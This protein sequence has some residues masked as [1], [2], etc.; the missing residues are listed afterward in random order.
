MKGRRTHSPAFT[1][2][3]ASETVKGNETVA[4]LAARSEVYPGQIFTWKQTLA[5]GTDSTLRDGQEQKSRND[6]LARR[7]EITL[8]ELELAREELL[9][10]CHTPKNSMELIV[11]NDILQ[12][13]EFSI[14]V[15]GSDERYFPL[16]FQWIVLS[17]LNPWTGSRYRKFLKVQ[18]R[19]RDFDEDTLLN[20][21]ENEL[22][23]EG[24]E[25]EGDAPTRSEDDSTQNGG[26]Y[27]G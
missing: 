17:I 1:R 14:V 11:V 12:M 18:R 23:V 8:R 21:E 26:P 24:R 20:N 2:K 27:A 6:R 7:R 22:V 3:V 19:W 13:T 9:P 5:E 4:Q 10:K 16:W 15:L 25:E